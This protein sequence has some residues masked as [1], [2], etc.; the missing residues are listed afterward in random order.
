MCC[1]LQVHAVPS[2]VRLEAEVR[3][4]FVFIHYCCAH[5]FSFNQMLCLHIKSKTTIVYF[6][7]KKLCNKINTTL[8]FNSYNSF[9]S[10]GW[11]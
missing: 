2:I 1:F 5:F 7:I 6:G 9:Y 8:G 3:V 11:F 4:F 10:H